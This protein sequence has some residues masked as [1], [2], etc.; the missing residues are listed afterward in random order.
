MQR[1]KFSRE[2]KL[3]AVKLVRERGVAVE[4][5][6]RDLDLHGNVVGQ[7][8][9]DAE[10]DPHSAFP[11]K[12]QMKP[13]QQQIERL[14]RE[15]SRMKAER[16]ILK[17]RGLLCQGQD[18]KFGFIAKHRGTWPVS[19]ICE[20]LDVSRSGFYAWLVRAA[21][22]RSRSD[23]EYAGKIRASLISSYRIYGARRVW[24]DLFTEGL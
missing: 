20:A 23:E 12:G 14:R 15:L 21:S 16:D 24:H 2:F 9:R 10:V 11:G 19:W 1:Q 6:A 8:V 3:E 18:M 5:A 13:E 22:A 4:Q 17:S 7:W